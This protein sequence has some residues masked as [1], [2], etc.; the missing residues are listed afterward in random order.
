MHVLVPFNANQT[1]VLWSKM[2]SFCELISN[3]S[4][5]DE[6]QLLL[7]QRKMLKE[8]SKFGDFLW[9]EQG[10]QSL[11]M[12]S[13]RMLHLLVLGFMTNVWLFHYG[14]FA[15]NLVTFWTLLVKK[16]L[17]YLWPSMQSESTCK[18]K[19]RKNCEC[20]PGHHLIV[21]HYSSI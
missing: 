16:Y 17:L 4:F 2:I 12:S 5:Q 3:V 19:H 6:N 13:E 9:F 18:D 1:F 20:C 21:D 10:T 15:E 8:K 7:T 14:I 11:Y